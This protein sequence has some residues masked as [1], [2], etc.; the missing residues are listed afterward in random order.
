MSFRKSM[1]VIEDDVLSV[2]PVIRHTET[3]SR[4]HNNKQIHRGYLL[5]VG[6]R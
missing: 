5:T 1:Y 4:T 6:V 3:K 2:K